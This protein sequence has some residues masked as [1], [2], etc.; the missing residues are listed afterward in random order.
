MN[1]DLSYAYDMYDEP[2]GQYKVKARTRAGET[3]VVYFRIEKDKIDQ[4]YLEGK[5]RIVYKGKIRV[6][7]GKIRD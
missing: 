3:L 2:R 6:D 7:K 5:A 1:F 4:V